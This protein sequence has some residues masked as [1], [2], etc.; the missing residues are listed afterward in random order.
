[1]TVK[2]TP[3]SP[4]QPGSVPSH[5]R[6]PAPPKDEIDPSSPEFMEA[7]RQLS[8]DF[9]LM[10]QKM[11]QQDP[12]EADDSCSGPG[13]GSSRGGGGSKYGRAPDD[14][15]YLQDKLEH[16]MK[17]VLARSGFNGSQGSN[18]GVPPAHGTNPPPQD[19]PPP[20]APADHSVA[21]HHLAH[22]AFPPVTAAAPPAKPRPTPS[23]REP[24]PT[25]KVADDA[26]RPAPLKPPP[27]TT[28][29]HV[30]AATKPGAVGGPDSVD[31][32]G[33]NKLHLVNKTDKP[34]T[35]AFFRNLARGEH[36]NFDGAEAQF[37]L[38]PHQSKDVSMPADW[39]G[40]VQK[41]SGSTQDPSNWAEIN[42]EKSTHKIWY[43]E[44]DI[45]GRN[46]SLKISSPDGQVAGADKSILGQAPDSL[47]KVDSSGQTVLKS[48]QWFDGK[49]NQ[50]AVDFL[51][52]ALGNTNAYVL[53]PDDDAV[54]TT[55]ANSLTVEFGD[56]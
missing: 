46:S 21:P 23:A 9:E 32:G 10:L 48:P 47:K 41:Y 53:P 26:A 5:G 35:V 8:L 33:P 31:G 17:N 51:D 56:A 18:G 28:S 54:R 27:T 25:G 37:T 55:N 4:D 15:Q 13:G 43:D 3:T 38:Q 45:L 50:G 30:P 12:S 2:A 6:A 44:S 52:K 42:F 49:T 11:Q 40:R 34:M 24:Q 22:T 36:P 14:M 16:D 19:L 1:M 20:A 39:Q 7:L 29:T